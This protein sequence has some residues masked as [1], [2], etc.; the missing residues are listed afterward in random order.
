MAWR[1]FSSQN[2]AGS[3]TVRL[4]LIDYRTV[5]CRVFANQENTCL[6]AGIEVALEKLCPELAPFGCFVPRTPRLGFIPLFKSLL[7]FRETHG[8]IPLLGSA[9]AL[10]TASN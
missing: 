5:Y 1:L 9:G 10:W 4:D 2:K 6:L 8:C 3:P 7:C